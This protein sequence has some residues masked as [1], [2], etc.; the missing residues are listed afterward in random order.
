MRGDH[1]SHGSK[2]SAYRFVSPIKIALKTTPAVHTNQLNKHKLRNCK[3]I[4]SETFLSVSLVIHFL[5]AF[6]HPDTCVLS[7]VVYRDTWTVTRCTYKNTHTHMHARTWMNVHTHIH[8]RKNTKL[9]FI[10][11][12]LRKLQ[13]F[14]IHKFITISK[15]QA[16]GDPKLR[17]N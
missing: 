14:M 7:G 1:P 13:T 15:R 8:T 10:M 4:W 2:T 12:L 6:R 9:W 11:T 16:D 5:T 17:T 3:F